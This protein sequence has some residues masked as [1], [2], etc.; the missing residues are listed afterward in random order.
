V[1]DGEFDR[2]DMGNT[3]IKG[4]THLLVCFSGN[5][6]LAVDEAVTAV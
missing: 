6:L 5:A 2:L 3:A 4:Y 1:T